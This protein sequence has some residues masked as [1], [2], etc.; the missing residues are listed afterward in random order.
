MKIE[1]YLK[2]CAILGGLILLSIAYVLL[3]WNK[4][5][6]L[7]GDDRIFHIER[8]EE[9]YHSLRAGHLPSLISTYS[10][11]KI[12]Q[13]IN[14]YYPWGSLLPYAIL[15]CIIK[16]PIHAYY[17]YIALEQFIGLVLTYLLGKELWHRRV[18]AIFLAVIFRFSTYIAFDD[19][20]RADFGESWALVFVPLTIL[21]LIKVFKD[22][23][24][25]GSILLAMGLSL[26]LYS[27]ILTT[28]ISILLVMIIYI[29]VLIDK[30]TSLSSSL[31]Y[32]ILSA[33]IFTGATLAVTVP[34][35]VGMH[36]TKI[37]SPG[38]DIFRTEQ[39]S[40]TD[41][42]NASVNNMVERSTPTVGIVIF[43]IFVFGFLFL[44]KMSK[45]ERESYVLGIILIFLSTELFP[46][47]LFAKTPV[48]NIQFTWRLLPIAS[49]FLAIYL[50][51]IFNLKIKNKK[52][53]LGITALVCLLFTY[54]SIQNY[55]IEQ[56]EYSSAEP[57]L[58][59]KI[60]HPLGYNLTEYSYEKALS[61]YQPNAYD[62]RWYGMDY[63]PRNAVDISGK[64]YDHI[65]L[66]NGEEYRMDNN[67]IVSSY[68]GV[69]FIIPS[70]WLAREENVV[71][72]P[73]VIYDRKNYSVY[74]DGKE[75][76]FTVTKHSQPII[77]VKKGGMMNVVVNYKTPRIIIISRYISLAI[78]FILIISMLIVLLIQKNLAVKNVVK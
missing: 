33:V 77:K 1:N 57:S 45:L 52:V 38:T 69:K 65:I 17:S 68:N 37:S 3:V 14:T 72:L 42:F 22:E 58:E 41:L 4:G 13:A 6:V 46:W 44:K 51:A 24:V 56:D 9:A 21:G 27:H 60:Q 26:T 75:V 16:N 47:S 29:V 5:L 59:N 25:L 74:R 78:L 23:K 19:F 43:A 30:R 34:I 2:K 40:F 53:I 12:G 10:F 15:R 35:L 8:F 31:K 62:V 18:T 11:S 39:I 66:V 28:I 55:L 64:I 70:K 54:G 73:F 20:A 36:S 67:S 50:A 63:L 61:L 76:N 49:I 48:A 32:F 71:T 7:P